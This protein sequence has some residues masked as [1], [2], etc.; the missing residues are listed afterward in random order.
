MGRFVS[1]NKQILGL[2]RMELDDK[3][4]DEII[5]IVRASP[6]SWNSCVLDNCSGYCDVL[7][8]AVLLTTKIRSLQIHGSS[9]NL[10][11]LG[12]GLANAQSLVEL[13]LTSISKGSWTESETLAIAK[14]LKNTTSLQDL[15]IQKCVFDRTELVYN[16]S[17]GLKGN[18]T[19]H[20]VELQKCQ[21]DDR[22]GMYLISS[23]GGHPCLKALCL[24]GNCFQNLTMEAIGT[25]LTAKDCQL[26]IIGLGSQQGQYD[27][28][29]SAIVAALKSN[30]S[31]RFLDLSGNHLK[32]DDVVDLWGSLQENT[33]LHHICLQNNELTDD[34]VVPLAGALPFL[35]LRS[36]RLEGHAYSQEVSNLVKEALDHNVVLEALSL[37]VYSSCAV[38]KKIRHHLCLNRAGRGLCRDFTQQPVTLLHHLLARVNRLWKTNREINLSVIYGL[39]LEHPGMF[40]T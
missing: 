26:E 8:A 28:D 27:L 30:R 18:R 14:G 3:E 16:L 33:T 9:N 20:R 6:D 38:H 25:R 7:L 23:L 15:S 29:V 31:V 37:G 22:E 36:I 21:L 1:S 11:A 19:L 35:S 39:L 12:M 17:D 32:D 24:A 5:D 13:S 10:Y 2:W 4:L 34:A 40:T